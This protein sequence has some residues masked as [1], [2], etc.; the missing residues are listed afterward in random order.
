MSAALNYYDSYR[1]E[2]LPH[3]MGEVEEVKVT[4]VAKVTSD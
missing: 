1:S 4:K 2:R 3:K